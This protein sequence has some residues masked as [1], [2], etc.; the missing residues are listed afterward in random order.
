MHKLIFT[1]WQYHPC[2]IENIQSCKHVPQKAKHT[3]GLYVE[4][5]FKRISAYITSHVINYGDL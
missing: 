1:I 2:F 4:E 5:D 3:Q